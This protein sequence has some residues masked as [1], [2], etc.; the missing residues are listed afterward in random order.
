MP[1]GRSED[2]EARRQSRARF[3]RGPRD[4]DLQRAREEARTEVGADL[5]QVLLVERESQGTPLAGGQLR[6][7][8]GP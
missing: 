8:E 2:A 7:E 3:A 5:G 1:G 4:A 6:R